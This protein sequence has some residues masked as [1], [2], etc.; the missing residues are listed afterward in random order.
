MEKKCNR[1]TKVFAILSFILVGLFCFTGYEM[2]VRAENNSFE[3]EAELLPANEETYDIRVSVSN[4]GKDWEGTVRVIYSEPYRMGNAYDTI[5]SLPQ[6][7]EKQFTVKLPMNSVEDLYGTLS[8]T[9]YD[10]K[11]KECAHEE[12]QDFMND[13]QNALVLGILSD[14]YYSLTGLDLG[15]WTL[16]YYGYEHPVVLQ[17][18]NQDN[19]LNYLDTL[20]FLVIDTFDTSVLSDD[21]LLAIEKWNAA[22]GVLIIGTGE[23][24][25]N[26]LALFEDSYL[27]V[28]CTS[29]QEPDDTLTYDYQ[30]YVDWTKVHMAYFW[31]SSEYFTQL[32]SR[33]LVRSYGNGAISILPYALT[34]VTAMN[35]SFYSST[36][37]QGFLYD[38]LVFSSEQSNNR[39]NNISNRGNYNTNQMSRTLRM[40]GNVGNDLQFGSLRV[41]IIIYVIFAGPVLYLILRFL[42]KREWYWVAV[43]VT[44]IVGIFVVF[45]AGRGFEVEDTRVYSI[46]T[47]NLSLD[48]A[49]ESYLYCFDAGNKEW[50]LELAD[51]YDYIGPFNSY[52]YSNYGDNNY[53]HHYTKAGDSLSIGIKPDAN[54]ADAFF[55]GKKTA[56]EERVEGTILFE[57]IEEKYT[58]VSGLITNT[59]EYDFTYF[60]VE[61]DGDATGTGSSLYVYEGLEAGEAIDLSKEV[62]VYAVSHGYDIW[63][64]Y[65]QDVYRMQDTMEN[66]EVAAMSALGFGL[67]C[68][69]EN[70][71]KNTVITDEQIRIVGV[72]ENWENVVDDDCTEQS[73]G[74]LYVAQ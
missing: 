31:T 25:Y 62:P 5:L 70:N 35:D 60:A 2:T 45:F 42:K 50:D 15:G 63:N 44:T 24:A 28:D 51:K 54:F 39:Y 68:A 41:I 36:D 1:W 58:N 61:I 26:T 22:G 55:M 34:E 52:Q 11:K 56:D 12:W 17:E 64:D 19:I 32:P 29:I 23:H 40:I 73:Y 57:D 20:E 27:E 43:P 21:V 67:F 3:I 16:Y 6:G 46:T 71:T 69:S 8:I 13:E 38:V 10:N 49:Q 18:L 48:E 33:M 4:T 30:D 14:D 72:V 47:Q 59:T 66:S 37:S 74:C 7:S 9:L 53:F 65:L